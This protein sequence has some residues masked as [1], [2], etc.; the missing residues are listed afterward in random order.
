MGAS[1][2]HGRGQGQQAKRVQNSRS[3]VLHSAFVVKRVKLTP[4]TGALYCAGLY[5]R[6]G[7]FDLL[8][9]EQDLPLA[10]RFPPEI[11]PGPTP[12]ATDLNYP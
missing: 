2:Q 12:C 11:S 1:S 7:S 10:V 5:L 4:G 8:H 9:R 3:G 6:G